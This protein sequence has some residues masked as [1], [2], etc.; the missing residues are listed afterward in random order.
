MSATSRINGLSFRTTEAKPSGPAQHQ[1]PQDDRSVRDILLAIEK[2]VTKGAEPA[3][4][5]AARSMRRSRPTAFP[6]RVRDAMVLAI[7][8]AGNNPG[9]LGITEVAALARSLDPDAWKAIGG[10]T[11]G[12][13][14]ASIRAL[15][16]EFVG[17]KSQWHKE[18]EQ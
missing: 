12:D 16:A 4:P 5:D 14:N 2:A 10:R 6:P 17:I 18:E 7:E 9:T 8:E 15:C 13:I 3:K 11:G 1:P